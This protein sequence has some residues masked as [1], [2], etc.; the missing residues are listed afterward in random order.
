[1]VQRISV[2][3]ADAHRLH[4]QLLA[5]LITEAGN[6]QLLGSA[7]N[8]AGL[9]Q[10]LQTHSP[11]V[12]IMELHLPDQSGIEFC[13]YLRQHHPSIGRIIITSCNQRPLMRRMRQAGPQA[14]LVKNSME[15]EDILTAINKVA[16]GGTFY[17]KEF[18]PIITG[19]QEGCPLAQDQQELLRSICNYEKSIAIAGKLC[20][21]K[22][23]VDKRRIKLMHDCN[24]KSII[25]LIRYG[26]KWAILDWSDL[27]E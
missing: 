11:D 21:S 20:L 26:L 7:Q 9:R 19:Q 17:C 27:F 4:R 3:V 8:G 13:H 25:D 10:L 23:A 18:T 2:I 6:L 5:R 16:A 22:P 1:M 15:E 12:V 14:Y 24:A